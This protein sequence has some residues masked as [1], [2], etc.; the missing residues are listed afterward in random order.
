MPQETKIPSPRRPADR[1]PKP[2][3]VD[4]AIS[5][6]GGRT[7]AL[8]ATPSRL[9]ASKKAPLPSLVERVEELTRENGEL[10]SEIGH[11]QEILEPMELFVKNVKCLHRK[12]ESCLFDF[13]EAQKAIEEDR[14]QERIH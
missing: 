1:P 5:L 11:Y 9:R 4:S 14:H 3:A 12:L 13:D 6:H 10:R 7:V 8:D 2:T